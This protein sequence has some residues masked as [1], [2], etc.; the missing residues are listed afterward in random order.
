MGVAFFSPDDDRVLYRRSY[1]DGLIMKGL[2]GRAAEEVV[3]GAE[4]VTSGA[5]SDLQQVNAIARKMVYQLGMGTETGLLIHDGEQGSLSA[6][7]HARMDREVRAMLERAYDRTREVI[8][9]NRESLAALAVALLERETIDGAEAV[10]IMEEAGLTRPP[11]MDARRGDPAGAVPAS[12]VT[13]EA[14]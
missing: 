11:W 7:A 3:F 9:D 14:A 4:S 6:E 13:S 1:L 12:A 8:L 5:Q 10:R 2:G